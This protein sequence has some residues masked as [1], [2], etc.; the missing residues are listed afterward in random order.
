LTIVHTCHSDSGSA[1]QLQW[2]SSRKTNSALQLAT[3]LLPL[4]HYCHADTATAFVTTAIATATPRLP[5]LSTLPNCHCQ[6]AAHCRTLPHC[7]CHCQ[8]ASHTATLPLL[9]TT[10]TTATATQRCRCHCHPRLLWHWQWLGGSARG[11]RGRPLAPFFHR[12]LAFLAPQKFK[13]NKSSANE[14][15]KGQD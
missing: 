9:A 4:P 2:Q 15:Q 5:Q 12:F 11:A 13:K 3:V 1:A 10:A 8:T 7:H 14:N 6:T